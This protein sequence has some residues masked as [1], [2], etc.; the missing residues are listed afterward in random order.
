MLEDSEPGT[1]VDNLIESNEIIGAG[2]VVI[3]LLRASRNQVVNNTITGVTVQD[4]FP[5]LPSPSSSNAAGA[6]GVEPRASA[7][8]FSVSGG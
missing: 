6:A 1:L 7:M 2:G 4:P 8:L 3:L 5:A